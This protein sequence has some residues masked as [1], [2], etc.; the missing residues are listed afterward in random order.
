MTEPSHVDSAP[1]KQAAATPITF[2]IYSPFPKYSGGRENWL[3]HLSPRLRERGRAVRVIAY[4]TNRAPFQP[5]EQSGID[6]VALPS[7]RYFYRAFSF[8][9]LATLGLLKYLDLFFLYPLIAAA[10]LGW[11]RPATLVCMNPVPEGLA[12]LLAG[13]PYAVSVRGDVPKGLS[14][15]PYSFLERPLRWLERLVLRRSR[16]VLANGRDTRERLSG[17]GIDSTIVPNG[18]DV[19]RF[20]EP[21]PPG[22]MGGEITQRAAGRPVIAFI[23]TMDEIHG[24]NDAID[25]AVQLKAL[26]PNFTLA[27]V[28]K[29]NAAAF[30]ER[31]LALGLAGSI[32]FMGEAESVLDVLQRSSI[33]LGLSHGNGMSMSA[34]E[35]MAAGVPIVARDALTYRQLIEDGTSGLLASG[36]AELADR[37]LR[38]LREPETAKRLALA[39]QAVVRDYDWPKVADI[40]LAELA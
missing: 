3:S 6:L 1:P 2:L 19:I 15:G 33:F 34:L 4:A 20:A 22:E 35:A 32:E 10:Y 39:A 25:L 38:L 36:P 12:A 37:C 28:G 26:E 29:G 7:V 9:N 14:S 27:M 21:A 18:V 17:D 40:F 24:V 23:A 5:M 31:A 13:V 11:K 30:R 8:L 16:K